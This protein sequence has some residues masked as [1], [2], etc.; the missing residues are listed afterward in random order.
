MSAV[1]LIHVR[2]ISTLH[3]HFRNPFSSQVILHPHTAV[4]YMLVLGTWVCSQLHISLQ[5]LMNV[6]PLHALIAAFFIMLYS[7]QN[8]STC[9]V[10]TFTLLHFHLLTV[11]SMLLVQMCVWFHL[12][13]YNCRGSLGPTMFSQ[14]HP[15]L[16]RNSRAKMDQV[17]VSNGCPA[18]GI[19]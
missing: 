3:V 10:F 7:V 18:N 6:P 19:Y 14:V 13:C 4:Q 16:A 11:L 1:L 8:L 15:C 2:T 17:C 9:T 5:Q 12:N